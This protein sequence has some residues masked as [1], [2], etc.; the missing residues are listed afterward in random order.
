MRLNKAVY[1][2][3]LRAQSDAPLRLAVAGLLLLLLYAFVANGITVNGASLSGLWALQ[4]GGNSLLLALLWL[5]GLGLISRDISGGSIQLVLLR[6]LSRAAYV[7]S[8]FS[9]LASVG[10]AV[11]IGMH[12]AAILHQGFDAFSPA[13]QGLLFAAQAAQVL[14][15][16]ALITLFSC[17][18]ARFGELGLLGLLLLALSLLKLLNLRWGLAPLDEA[19]AFAFRV[20][21]PSAALPNASGQA[22]AWS[23]ALNAAV[24]LSA[25]AGAVRLL[26][27]REFSYAESA[28]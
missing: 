6:P 7:L 25:L 18:P 16:S 21:L 24:G 19:V 4:K 9:A 26:V 23:L 3:A 12:A 5:L 8:K 20:L 14:A 27:R 28:A 1:L 17:V 10:L 22:W 15:A 11:L 13:E 2:H